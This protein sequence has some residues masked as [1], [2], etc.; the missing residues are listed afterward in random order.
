MSDDMI[1]SKRG[2]EYSLKDALRRNPTIIAAGDDISAVALARIEDMEAKLAKAVVGLGL[3][4][5][6]ING[7]VD[8]GDAFDEIKAI[9]AELLKGDTYNGN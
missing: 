1:R 9:L 7:F 8:S 3:A 4:K 6:A 2:Y 5:D